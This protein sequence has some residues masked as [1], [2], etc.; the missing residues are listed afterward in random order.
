VEH[1]V[2]LCS[3]EVWGECALEPSTAPF[4]SFLSLLP[5]RA[6]DVAGLDAKLIVL[7]SPSKVSSHWP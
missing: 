6:G 4:T 7:T 1:D 5:G 3:D 2:V